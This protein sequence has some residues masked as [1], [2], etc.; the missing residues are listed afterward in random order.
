MDSLSIAGG[1]TVVGGRDGS[2]KDDFDA[3]PR[4]AKRHFKGKSTGAETT[5]SKF[6]HVSYYTL[7]IIKAYTLLQ[8]I[9][10]NDRP[11]FVKIGKDGVVPALTKLDEQVRA[12]RFISPLL[13]S[14]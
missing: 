11:F 13:P 1:T 7:Y 3:S 2:D 4:L 8:P 6:Q 12:V 9:E 10:L 14:R 5:I